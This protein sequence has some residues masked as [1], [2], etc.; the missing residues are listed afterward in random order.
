M[1][2]CER[3]EA[4]FPDLCGVRKRRSSQ[5]FSGQELSQSSVSWLRLG[6]GSLGGAQLFQPGGLSQTLEQ[7]EPM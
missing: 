1:R 2:M 7:L 5:P 3:R 6:R 4:L